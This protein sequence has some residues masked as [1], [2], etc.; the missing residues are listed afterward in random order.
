MLSLVP[1]GRISDEAG[2]VTYR[3]KGEARRFA[4]GSFSHF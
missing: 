2:V 4:Q 1:I 3:E